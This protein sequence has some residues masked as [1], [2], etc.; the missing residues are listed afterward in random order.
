MQFYG[1][2]CLL[3]KYNNGVKNGFLTSN[4][5]LAMHMRSP[6]AQTTHVSYRG[7]IVVAASY[8]LDPL[9]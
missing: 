5:Q 9:A 4:I 2:P 6:P 8:S 3:K 1:T 7:D